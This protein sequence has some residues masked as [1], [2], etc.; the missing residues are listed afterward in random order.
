M[1]TCFRLA[2]LLIVTA[3]F[4]MLAATAQ[5]RPARPAP[6]AQG[7]ARPE[8]TPGPCSEASTLPSGAL[9]SYCVPTS[10]WNG[11]LVIWAHGYVAPGPDLVF[12]NRDELAPLVQSQGFA[13]ATT[14]YRRNGLAILEGVQDI[15]ELAA[16]FPSA[17]GRAAPVRTYL[18]GAS[19]G[20]AVVTLLIERYP[21]EFAGGLATC[22]PI[23][24]FRRQI[25][26]VA[27]FRVLFDY[28]FPGV[29]PGSPVQIPPELIAN[30]DSTYVPAIKAALA[31]NP[32]AARQLIST[33]KGAIDPANPASV[34][35]TTLDVLWYNVFATNDVRAQLGG[36]PYDNR[37]KRYWGSDDDRQLNAGVQRF[38]AD[39][40]AL[41]ALQNYQST[42]NTSKPLVTMHTT[43][44]AIVPFWQQVLYDLRY[45]GNGGSNHTPIVINRYG[46]C[47]FTNEETL[48]AFQVLLHRVLVI[49]PS[50]I[51]L[52]A[53]RAAFNAARPAALAQ[54]SPPN[55]LPALRR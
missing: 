7:P 55:Y 49:V 25:N 18:V 37:S 21:N 12:P 19:E 33:T 17:T 47:N 52:N 40:A 9:A 42:A 11:D 44:D 23:G 22:G 15:R 20:G 26:Y 13:F 8:A 29:L 48:A 28:F 53:N 4:S 30:W 54:L 45:Q 51:D 32:N 27:D 14:S 6:A 24:D 35:Q 16:A 50:P 3:A 34:E 1:R 39:A 10:G 36:N 5:A 43:G 41:A 38:S 46:H 2:L 31:A